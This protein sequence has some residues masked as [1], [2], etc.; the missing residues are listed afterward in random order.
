MID[1]TDCTIESIAIYKMIA[2]S[3]NSPV[4]AGEVSLTNEMKELLVHY[5]FS[6]FK[7]D[8]LYTFTPEALEEETS[9]ASQ[10]K[11]LFEDTERF[12]ELA[13][14]FAE[15]LQEASSRPQVK[16]GNLYV[17]LFDG[18]RFRNEECKAVGLFKAEVK[19]TYINVVESEDGMRIER[20][21]GFS[22]NKIDKG[23]LI[24]NYDAQKGF[25]M[26][27][28]DTTNK[29]KSANYWVDSFLQAQLRKD[30]KFLTKNTLKNVTEF[31]TKELPKEKAISKMEQIDVLNKTMDYLKD[32]ANFKTEDYSS[33]VLKDDDT[34][35]K[36]REFL[37]SRG[38][39]IGDW[40]NFPISEE[41]VQKSNRFMKRV[42]KLG[43]DFSI[44]VH[45]NTDLM[46]KGFD[47]S[48][49]LQFYQF[50]FKDEK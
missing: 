46:K 14:H 42:I 23:C 15:I 17:V 9:V 1:V 47:S 40:D 32:N 2:K 19:E 38:D 21:E 7:N 5:F 39:D 48:S 35:Q 30:S 49:G 31:V 16:D 18:C 13:P 34:K 36:F 25:V 27:I 28:I 43:K 8:Q 6:S 45:G 12:D 22:I 50:F 24:C 26:D 3:E 41:T 33:S 37:S 4:C 29:A 11:A 20:S 44:Y 10:V